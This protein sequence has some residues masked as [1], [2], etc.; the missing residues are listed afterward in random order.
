MEGWKE[1]TIDEFAALVGSRASKGSEHPRA[2]GKHIVHQQEGVPFALQII[3][4]EGNSTFLAPIA[5]AAVSDDIGG[6]DD[7]PAGPGGG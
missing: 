4:L 5:S 1:I 2:D 6:T 3:D 7:P